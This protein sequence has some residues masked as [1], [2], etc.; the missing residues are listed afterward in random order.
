MAREPTDARGWP[1]VTWLA[2]AMV[3]GSL[4]VTAIWGWALVTR[5]T[6][7]SANHALV[8]HLATAVALATIT[9]VPHQGRLVL[10][11]DADQD[12]WLDPSPRRPTD[13]LNGV[14]PGPLTLL[15]SEIPKRSVVDGFVVDSWGSPLRV[16]MTAGVMHI[17]SDGP[18]RVP[19]TVDDI[20]SDLTG[21]PTSSR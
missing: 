3:V 1:A 19:A 11:W 13:P 8:D 10:V 12:G 20:R 7:R 14:V 6:Q 16:E 18:D 2:L 9:V 17:V 4:N 21:G 15:N 5:G